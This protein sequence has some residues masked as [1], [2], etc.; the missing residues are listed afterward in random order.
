MTR[1]A[2]GLFLLCSTG[3]AMANGGPPKEAPQSNGPPIAHE[4]LFHA[5]KNVAIQRAKQRLERAAAFVR[6][7]SDGKASHLPGFGARP[8]ELGELQFRNPEALYLVLGARM[9]RLHVGYSLELKLGE[10]RNAPWVNVEMNRHGRI[11][12]RLFAG[13]D[14]LFAAAS[15][16][17]SAEVLATVSE[18]DFNGP[19]LDTFSIVQARKQARVLAQDPVAVKKMLMAM[20]AAQ[21][22]SQEAAAP[23]PQPRPQ[24]QLAVV[25]P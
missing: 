20:M 4:P 17:L 24:M 12:G 5:D 18:K 3:S 16:A 23:A 8:F 13:D 11:A 14:S 19:R 22:A 1:A 10:D 7:E 15:P 21:K 2:I 9:P 6:D 25:N